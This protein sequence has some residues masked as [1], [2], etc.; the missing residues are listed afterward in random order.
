MQ[1]ELLVVDDEPKL[2]H[3]LKAFFE[4]KGFRVETATTGHTALESLTRLPMPVVFLD[5][6]LPDGS[7]L[8]VLSQ[9][10]ARD[11][12]VRVVV[13]SGQSDPETIQEALRRGANE[14]L[15][16]PLDFARC[17]Y[18]AMGIETV[19]LATV[20]VE[21]NA[22]QRVPLSVAQGSGVVPVRT[23]RGTLEVAMS[24]PLDHD[25]LEGLRAQL[26]CDVIP[27]AA[28]GGDVASAI[29]RVYGLDA[30]LPPAPS[31]DDASLLHDLLQQGW[32]RHAQVLHLGWGPNGP[33]MR[34]RIDGLW[35]DASLPSEAAEV[36]SRLLHR[37]KRLAGL[38]PS[39]RGHLR[40]GRG[41]MTIAGTRLTL[42]VSVA[43]TL[44]GEHIIIRLGDP[45][46]RVEMGELGLSEGQQEQLSALLSR[47]SGLVLVT[48]PSG[49]GLSTT[50]S[51]CLSRV[52]AS[53][54][55]VVTLEDPPEHELPQVTQIP[56][57][58]GSTFADGLRAILR[59]EPDVVMVG[60]LPDADAV[61]EAVRVA[62][63]G[64]LVLS[65]LHAADTAGSIRRMLD[66]GIEPFLLCATLSGVVSQRLL[67]ALCPS[68]REPVEVETAGLLQAGLA[69]P[70]RAGRITLRRAGRC[71]QCRQ[72]GYQGRIGVFEVL[73]VDHHIRALMIKHTSS[74]QIRQSAISR[75]MLSLWQAGWQAVSSGVTSLEELTRGLLPDLRQAG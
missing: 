37:V 73:T 34:E 44:D 10:K 13:I 50:L 18:A 20:A 35:A 51:T 26:G 59:H 42:Q 3:A 47:P 62:L 4:A 64:R 29:R 69:V 9:F 52:D 65:S 8:D 27:L 31:L 74:S 1:R 23:S 71:P 28:I 32:R 39:E 72:T 33:W 21:S 48:G 6:R 15:T 25:Q 58:A 17:F 46:R 43:P 61:R 19:D 45:L 5:L 41:S 60:G 49:A 63:S 22:I 54:L 38:D 57:E 14:Y 55:H 56:L 30:S 11:P 75:G 16:K 24:D 53:R 66:F 68:C 7:G 70:Q 40:W 67:R 12:S 2:C 36:Y